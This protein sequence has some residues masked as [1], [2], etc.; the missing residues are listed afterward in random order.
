MYSTNMF[1]VCL[2]FALCVPVICQLF[3]HSILSICLRLVQLSACLPVYSKRLPVQLPNQCSLSFFILLASP[4][5]GINNCRT[6]A[7]LAVKTV[8][9]S[10]SSTPNMHVCQFNWHTAVCKFNCQTVHYITFSLFVSPVFSLSVS[11]KLSAFLSVQPVFQTC[12][13]VQD[14]VCPPVKLSALLLQLLYNKNAQLIQNSGRPFPYTN[15]V[16]EAK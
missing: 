16:N 12:L 2:H 14:S 10:T 3:C 4:K 5:A 15:E 9:L 13:P 11:Y 7:C 8:N 6:T 1:I